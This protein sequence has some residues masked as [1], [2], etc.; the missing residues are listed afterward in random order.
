MADYY[1]VLGVSEHASLEEIKRAY[2]RLMKKYHPDVNKSKNAEA[3][4]KKQDALSKALESAKK[5]I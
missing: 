2:K 5:H 3:K 4:A 1:K